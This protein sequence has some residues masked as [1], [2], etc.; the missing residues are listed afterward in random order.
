SGYDLH[1]VREY[2]HGESL[3]RVDWKSTAKRGKLMVRELE[4]SPRDEACVVLDCE[5]GLNVGTA[6]DSSFEMQVRIAAAVLRHLRQAGARGGTAARSGRRRR[7]WRR[8]RS[9]RWRA[10]GAPR[11]TCWPACATTAAARWP[12][13]SRTSARAS[14]RS[15]STS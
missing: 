4:D 15:A 11:S 9:R 13:C 14:T 5:G 8:R 2:Q 7:A 1:S 3:R 10:T 6:P 12:P